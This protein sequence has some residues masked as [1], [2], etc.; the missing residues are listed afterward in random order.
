MKYLEFA[1][2]K[3]VTICT[4]SKLKNY[5]SCHCHCCDVIST[6]HYDNYYSSQRLSLFIT[7]P[8]P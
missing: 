5:N 7:V 4:T 8:G 3:D 2:H 6:Q 1:F